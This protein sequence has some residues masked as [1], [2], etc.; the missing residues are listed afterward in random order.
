MRTVTLFTVLSQTLAQKG[1]QEVNIDECSL[2]QSIC[3]PPMPSKSES[4]NND[5]DDKKYNINNFLERGK[6]LLMKSLGLMVVK[7][8][9]E[10]YD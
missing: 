5:D 3:R 4:N 8:R 1:G 6:F 7:R 2:L 9:K 10:T